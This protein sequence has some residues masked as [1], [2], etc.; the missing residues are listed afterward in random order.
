VRQEKGRDFWDIL[1][2]YCALLNCKTIII[3]YF[4]GPLDTVVHVC[5][6]VEAEGCIIV[7]HI[8]RD[9]EVDVSLRN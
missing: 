6:L 3:I 1:F 8:L 9:K 5:V 4:M 7:T 2:A